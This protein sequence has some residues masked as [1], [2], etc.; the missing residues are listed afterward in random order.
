MKKHTLSVSYSTAKHVPGCIAAANSIKVA[1]RLRFIGDPPPRLARNGQPYMLKDKHGDVERW[2]IPTES[3][4][5]IRGAAEDS[6]DDDSD[7]SDG[8]P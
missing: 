3:E 7:D 2:L 1:V 4:E 6:S 8:G 5:L